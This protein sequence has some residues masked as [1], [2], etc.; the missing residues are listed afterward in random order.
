MMVPPPKQLIRNAQSLEFRSI[1]KV[2]DYLIQRLVQMLKLV[3]VP[4]R[5]IPIPKGHKIIPKD[6]R[7]SAQFPVTLF[8]ELM[9][10]HLIFVKNQQVISLCN[11]AQQENYIHL[12]ADQQRY[13]I[14]VKLKP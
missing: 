1:N 12:N 3:I 14:I 9:K 10:S 2:N 6:H 13:E 4:S 11:A 8:Q 7:G 5:G